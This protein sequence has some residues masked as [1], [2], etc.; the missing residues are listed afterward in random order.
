MET[1]KNFLES[2]KNSSKTPNIMTTIILANEKTLKISIC[3]LKHVY[4]L[5]GELKS[6]KTRHGN[7]RCSQ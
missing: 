6:K 1:V 3:K 7:T 4:G 2:T 5:I